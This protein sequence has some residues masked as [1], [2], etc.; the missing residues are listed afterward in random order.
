MTLRQTK[1]IVGKW[2]V[3]MFQRNQHDY[4]LIDGCSHK[5]FEVHVSKTKENTVQGNR[6]FHILIMYSNNA[7][8]ISMIIGSVIPS[9]T[10]TLQ[11]ISVT[12]LKIVFKRHAGKAALWTHDLEA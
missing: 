10:K 9:F 4:R 12:V 3:E 11:F 1:W 2:I 8:N 7:I 6:N 5:N